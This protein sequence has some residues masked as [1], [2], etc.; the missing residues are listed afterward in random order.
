MS[1]WAARNVFWH[2]YPLGFTS[3]EKVARA[4]GAV[5]HRLPKLIMW[6]D[7]AVDLGASGLLLRA[8]LSIVQSRLR[9]HG[10]LCHRPPT[11]TSTR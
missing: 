7:Y 1:D 3:A 9:H 11:R 6:L 2:V 5:V 8:N 10:L 4:E